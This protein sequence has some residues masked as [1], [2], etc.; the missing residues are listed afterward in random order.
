MTM[1]GRCEVGDVLGIV[2]GDFVEIGRDVTAVAAAVAARLLAAGGELLT[3]VL[4]A[5]VPDDLA[6]ALTERVRR[7]PGAVEVQVLHGGQ[8]R[9]PV[10]LGAE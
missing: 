9:Y 1:A 5:D 10:L 2:D 4:G 7:H 3:V 6:A 8:P